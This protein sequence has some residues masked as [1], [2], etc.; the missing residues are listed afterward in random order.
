MDARGVPTGVAQFDDNLSVII[1]LVPDSDHVKVKIV[2][3]HGSEEPAQVQIE[4]DPKTLL[5]RWR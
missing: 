2:K 5:L 3:E 4:L 1:N